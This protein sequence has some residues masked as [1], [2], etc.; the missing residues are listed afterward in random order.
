MNSSRKKKPKTASFDKNTVRR[1]MSC[2]RGYRATNVLIVIC[3]LLSAVAS[4]ASSMFLENLIDDYILPLLKTTHPVYT[5]L[6]RVLIVM[7]IIYLAGTIGTLVYN[8]LAVTVAQGTLKSIRDDMFT[9]MQQLPIRFFD[10][11]AH[12]DIMSLY[13][14]DTDTLRQM[15]AQSLPQFISSAL[16]MAAVFCCMLYISVWLTLVVVICIVV[17]MKIIGV[18]AA[19]S[20][21]YFSAQQTA[22]ADVDGYVEEMINGQK[23]IKVFCHEEESVAGL[24]QRNEEW[25]KNSAAANAQAS[26]ILPLMNAF[27]YVLYIILAII[28]G[29]MAIAGVGNYGVIAGS[30]TV[31]LGMIASF[32]TL[33]RNFI[34]PLSQI[35]NQMNSVI[36]ALAGAGRIFAF[37]EEQPEADEGTVTLV[38]AE[39]SEDGGIREADRRTGQW[40]WKQPRRDGTVSFTKLTGAIAMDHV[41]FGYDPEKIV[42]HDITLTARPGEKIAF[43][44]ATG[45]GKTTITNLINRFYDIEDG[46]I[47]YDG[48]NINEIKKHDLRRSLGVVLQEVNLFTGT[49]MENIRFGRPDADDGECIAAARLANADNFIRMLPNGYDTVITGDGAGLSQGQRQLISIA[50]AAVSDPPV[51]ILDEA[52]SSIDTR[53][54]KLVQDGMDRL[55]EGRTVFVI[56]HRLSTVRNADVI[57]VLDHGTIIEQGSHEALL[58]QKGMYYQLCTGAFELE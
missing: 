24:R 16:T 31:T 58:E 57:I 3:I 45:A 51:M 13:T 12:G 52:T 54:E 18:V 32:L 41:D 44:G 4:A 8:R 19:R 50:R 46:K 43:V 7:G 21:K 10:R 49:V 5:S 29:C 17:I 40:A 25:R 37:M 42:L 9:K 26:S 55:M 36:T 39:V 47:R 33:S 35:S 28:G 14:N 22:L 30:N 56:A 1:L 2:M 27:G 20:G 53:T 48:I 38:D 23:V 11:H 6:I 34:N 15:I